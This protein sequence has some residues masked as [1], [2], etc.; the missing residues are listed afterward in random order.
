[1]KLGPLAWPGGVE[2]FLVLAA[3]SAACV[4]PDESLCVALEAAAAFFACVFEV[5]PR[6]ADPFPEVF[7]APPLESSLDPEVERVDD[8]VV[9]ELAELPPVPDELEEDP[10][11]GTG[12][13]GGGGRM[14]VGRTESSATRSHSLR[15]DAL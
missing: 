6:F 11:A 15:P 14:G 7:A 3:A 4:W 2:P 8:P 9:V 12:V 1:M 5:A 13:F 10:A